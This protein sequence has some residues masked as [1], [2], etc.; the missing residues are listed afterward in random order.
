MSKE[1]EKVVVSGI[2][3]DDA[4]VTDSPVTRGFQSNE[5]RE[6]AMAK[7]KGEEASD[8]PPVNGLVD[9]ALIGQR[10]GEDPMKKMVKVRSNK[11][12][13]P[14]RFGG[15]SYTLP[16][17]RETIIPLAVKKHLEEKGIL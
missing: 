12:V 2:V 11:F 16:E 10:V 14:F 9:T 15:V 1:K 3:E 5:A 8:L 7:N 13:A 4:D 17:K 6:V